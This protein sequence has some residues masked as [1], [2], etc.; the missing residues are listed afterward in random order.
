MTDSSRDVECIRDYLVGRMTEE[1]RL[2]FQDRL[3]RDPVLAREFE[4]SLQ[5]HEGL[6]ELVAQNYFAAATPKP[7]I[8]T[9][10]GLWYRAGI[11]AAAVIVGVSLVVAWR[12]NQES[13]VLT[14]LPTTRPDTAPLIAA[15]FTFVATRD[16]GRPRLALPSSG[17]VEWRASPETRSAASYRVTLVRDP[18]GGAAQHR[19]GVATGLRLG[20]DGYV[21]CYAD[22]AQLAPGTYGLRIEPSEPGP[23]GTQVF[24]F[25]LQPPGG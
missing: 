6:R 13:S 12:L 22:S 20:A 25:V 19:V 9:T 23:A 7:R 3:A 2:A 14:A 4:E 24:L 5:L 17:L 10:R 15:Q 18:E 1:E 8:Q 16:A 21:H 11:A